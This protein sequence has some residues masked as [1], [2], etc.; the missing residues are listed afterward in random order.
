[1]ALLS[2]KVGHYSRSCGA[3]QSDIDVHAEESLSHCRIC[4]S[5]LHV[6][7]ACNVAEA[8]LTWTQRKFKRQWLQRLDAR[9]RAAC[10]CS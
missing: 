10:S 3:S 7:S 4:A 8:D 6:A 5:K 1:M 2:G 9:K